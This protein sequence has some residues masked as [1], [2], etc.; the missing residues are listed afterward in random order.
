MIVI[1]DFKSVYYILYKFKIRPHAKFRI[2][3]LNNSSIYVINR[4][5][6]ILDSPNFEHLY[7]ERTLK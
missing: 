6:K 5:Q 4:R 7:F 2:S 1:F 3:K